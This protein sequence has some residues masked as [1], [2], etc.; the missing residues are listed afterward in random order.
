[1][2]HNSVCCVT[3]RQIYDIYYYFQSLRKQKALPPPYPGFGTSLYD[4]EI[5][6]QP[7]K[8]KPTSIQ[9]PLH[10]RK[11]PGKENDK[12]LNTE[13]A[14]DEGHNFGQSENAQEDSMCS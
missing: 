6:G 2:C 3:N 12:F 8:L 14:N 11:A 9:N 4:K 7:P 10:D 13:A 5:K 1:M